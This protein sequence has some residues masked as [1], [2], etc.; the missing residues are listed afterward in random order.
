MPTVS[1]IPPRAH[2]A[3]DAMD[4]EQRLVDGA[5]NGD[6]A[7]FRELVER[8]EDLVGATV[9]GMLG[10]GAEAED[11][12]QLTFV[13]FYEA[14]SRYQGSGGV[15]PYVTRT[16]IN[17]SLNALDRRKRRRWRFL[18]RDEH[19]GLPEPETPP[20]ATDEGRRKLVRHALDQLS[21]EHRAVV[22][23]R[24]IN[25]YS[26]VE[27]AN[28]LGVPTGT[29]LSRLSRAQERLKQILSPFLEDL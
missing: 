7:A 2:T 9:I 23:L 22:V 18:S 10:P 28:L 26:T 24:I 5:R 11:T 19:R 27:T 15:A 14:L 20:P 13:R 16:A 29:V 8:Y 4:E 21:P 3:S 12:A 17:L 6:Q 25:G 1:E